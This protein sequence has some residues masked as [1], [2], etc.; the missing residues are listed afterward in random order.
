MSNQNLI[1]PAA[2]GRRQF[3][4]Q[5]GPAV[6][7]PFLACPP[8]PYAGL[9]CEPCL[10][11]A[12]AG[13]AG[14]HQCCCQQ[15]L[16]SAAASSQQGCLAQAVEDSENPRAGAFVSAPLDHSDTVM[17]CG[18]QGIHRAA[19]IFVLPSSRRCLCIHLAEPISAL[20]HCSCCMAGN[21]LF[22]DQLLPPPSSSP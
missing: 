17:A 6:Q 21:P 14:S 18:I 22:G 15:L 10:P 9:V 13:A 12:A 1:L 5:A 8:W 7:E 20:P 4:G 16:C 19:Q 2:R 11:R 3:P